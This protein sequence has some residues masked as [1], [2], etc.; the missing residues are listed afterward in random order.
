MKEQQAVLFLWFV[1]LSVGG[2]L[3]Y[4]ILRALRREIKHADWVVMIEDILFSA[5]FCWG[6][7]SIFLQKNHG[8]LRAYGLIGMLVGVILYD[9]TI[10]RW[11]LKGFRCGFRII[12][13]PMR[14]LLAKCKKWKSHRK[15]L[16]NR[17]R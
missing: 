14:W 13:A 12:L 8:A 16:T 2:R 15:A 1:G 5:F 9:W 10:G 7:Y 17:N 3:V 4:D 11:I 6:C